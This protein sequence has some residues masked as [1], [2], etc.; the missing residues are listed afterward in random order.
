MDRC[1]VDS[2]ACAGNQ[3]SVD[4]QFIMYL[5]IHDGPRHASPGCTGNDKGIT[6]L[7][8]FDQ[9]GKAPDDSDVIVM[10]RRC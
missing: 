2:A 10:Y 4:H 5:L 6:E 3:P 7:Q 9:P 8:Q 1:G